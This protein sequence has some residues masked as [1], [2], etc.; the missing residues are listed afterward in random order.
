[1]IIVSWYKNVN[2]MVINEN[3][4]IIIKIDILTQ[5]FRYFQYL[6]TYFNIFT[7]I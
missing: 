5:L 3:F 2:N 7:C 6:N 4:G 1:M